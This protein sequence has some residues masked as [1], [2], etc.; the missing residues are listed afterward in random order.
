MIK[1]Q[2]FGID[3]D[4][5]VN[6]TL[7]EM[8]SLI[9]NKEPAER[10]KKKINDFKDILGNNVEDDEA[11][12]TILVNLNKDIN[13]NAD[14]YKGFL[15]DDFNKFN[16]N[17]GSMINTIKYMKNQSEYRDDL[18]YDNFIRGYIG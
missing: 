4:F 5:Q 15:G 18:I 16:N 2:A 7:N 17:L 1:K 3:I 13:N 6:Y 14:V 12:V 9:P 11:R 10:I 8:F